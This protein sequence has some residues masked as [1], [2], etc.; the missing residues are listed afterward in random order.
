[1]VNSMLV[2]VSLDLSWF[3]FAGQ[4]LFPMFHSAFF[5]C[6]A[7]PSVQLLRFAKVT[8]VSAVCLTKMW[9]P[10]SNGQYPIIVHNQLV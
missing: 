4:L 7:L 10:M 5:A 6:L 1:M 3:W 9:Q 2:L 8:E